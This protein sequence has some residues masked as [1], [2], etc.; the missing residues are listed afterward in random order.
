MKLH[1]VFAMAIAITT[2]SLSHAHEFKLKD[3]HIG[4]PYARTTVANQPS[5]A[6][7]LTLENK[8]RS[9]DKLVSV[10]SPAAKSVQIHSM[11]ME[12]NVMKMREVDGIELPP[13][14]KVEMKPGHGYH[15]MLIGLQQPLK[16]GNKFP[17][18]LN[19]E[20]SGKTEVTVVVEAPKKE[21]APAGG[22]KHH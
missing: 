5:G 11:S 14:S 15:I 6:A 2:S 12:G 13:A 19:F 4:H 8:G 17:L 10:A 18:T 9:T 22:H 3:L 16:A 20:K 21:E 7:Y 1:H